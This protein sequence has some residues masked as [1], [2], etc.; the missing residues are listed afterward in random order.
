MYIPQKF[1]LNAKE[2]KTLFLWFPRVSLLAQLL[3]SIWDFRMWWMD[4]TPPQLLFPLPPLSLS[5]SRLIFLKMFLLFNPCHCQQAWREG[6]RCQWK[7]VFQKAAW[8][9]HGSKSSTPN[10]GEKQACCQFDTT[11]R[12]HAETGL[13]QHRKTQS[14]PYN[15]RPRWTIT[16]PCQRILA[17]ICYSFGWSGFPWTTRNFIF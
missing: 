17:L 14:R 6:R 5:L 4:Y 8:D 13:L 7:Q 12:N 10:L 15:E 3:H 1:P 16:Q 2:R 11:L 9:L